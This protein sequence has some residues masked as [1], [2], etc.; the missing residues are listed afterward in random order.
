[1][2]H[3]ATR[4]TLHPCRAPTPSLECNEA[5][6]IPS[7]CCILVV[8][9]NGSEV[10]R[11]PLVVE[12]L[13]EFLDWSMQWTLTQACKADLLFLARRIVAAQELQPLD[14][15]L[16]LPGV[17]QWQFTEG[18][19]SAVA[20]GNLALVELLSTRFHGCYVQSSVVEEAATLGRTEI[21]QWLVRNRSDMRWTDREVAAAIRAGQFE[22]AKWMK[23]KV[24]T[25][26]IEMLERW[27]APAAGKGDLEMLKWVCSLSTV[28]NPRTAVFEAVDNGHLEVVK[29]IMRQPDRNGQVLTEAD[30]DLTQIAVRNATLVEL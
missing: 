14:S 24:A 20:A 27:A 16:R 25:A 19:T 17:R 10:L 15:G 6:E 13:H 1:M 7:L 21:L 2:T 28:V 3:R 29:W 4:L 5:D 30:A 9:R 8:C 26:S 22:L 18:V 12:K 23:G 11:L